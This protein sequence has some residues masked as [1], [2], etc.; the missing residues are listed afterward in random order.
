M[1]LKIIILT[2]LI[3][4]FGFSQKK[5]KVKGNKFVKV[6]QHQI[7]EFNAL[8]LNDRFEIFLL[9][10]VVP[11]VEIETDEN[12]HDVIQFNV[13]D[14]GVLSFNTTHHISSKKKLNI[15]VTV[16]DQFNS[17]LTSEKA[18][19]NSLIDLDLKTMTIVAKDNSK[20]FLTLKTDD[21]NLTTD[22]HSKVELNLNTAKSALTLSESSNLKA[23]INADE[24]NIDLYQ[25][26]NAKIEGEVTSLHL[27][28][29]NA[30][31]YHG[32]KL[33]AQ[34]ATVIAEGSS[35]CDLDV[36]NK[37]TLEASGSTKVNIHN[38]P[39]IELKRFE[40]SAAIYKK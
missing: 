17:I 24:L 5:E 36:K 28:S 37:L 21:F 6:K 3:S 29:D 32:E 27:R 30:S 23:L 11:Q 40:D 35:D 7:A 25:K 33:T 4:S 9:K 18:I 31:N 15:R 39:K 8:N 38:S 19:V 34:D 20:L 10:G 16:T 1:K 2:L 22:K 12:L 26:A 13:S 14:K